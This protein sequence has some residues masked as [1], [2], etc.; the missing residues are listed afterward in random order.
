MDTDVDMH[1]FPAPKWHELDGGNYLGTAGLVIT[2]DPDEGWVN[3]GTY[4]VQVH[5]RDTVGFYISPGKHGRIMREKYWA[6]G[7]PCPV[8]MCFGMDPLLLHVAST[9]LPWGAS[10]YDYAGGIKGQPIEVIKG[11]VTGLPIPA[12]AEIVIEGLSYPGDMQMEGPFGEFAG[13]YASGERKEPIVKV[14]S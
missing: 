5:D 14:K 10:E 9:G 1:E 11:P 8:A 4:R 7:E 6:K 2:R 13:Y 12:A 3:L